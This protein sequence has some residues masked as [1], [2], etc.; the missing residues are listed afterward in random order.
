MPE[1]TQSLKRAM[2]AEFAGKKKVL[3]DATVEAQ[4][5]TRCKK[6]GHTAFSCPDQTQ[7]ASADETAEHRWVRNLIDGPRVNIAE[8]NATL[9]LSEG[10]VRWKE[11]GRKLN[12]GNPWA[13]SMKKEDLFF[14]SIYANTLRWEKK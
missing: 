10:V 2:Q 13:N 4:A 8:T 9:S 6:A 11:E 1:G 14:H 12:E 7:A 5:C 3:S